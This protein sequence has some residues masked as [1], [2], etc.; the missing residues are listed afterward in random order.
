MPC[1]RV[2]NVAHTCSHANARNF[3]QCNKGETA[4][5]LEKS[6]NPLKYVKCIFLKYLS[7]DFNLKV[8]I[9]LL[10]RKKESKIRSLNGKMM[11][12]F[13]SFASCDSLHAA[14]TAKKK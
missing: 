4:V 11:C 5:V 6:G 12:T 3:V 14:V 10:E 1:Q 13:T 9:Y 7:A 2:T 8:T